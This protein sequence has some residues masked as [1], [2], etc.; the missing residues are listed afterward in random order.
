MFAGLLHKFISTYYDDAR[1]QQFLL[2]TVRRDRCVIQPWGLGV[3]VNLKSNTYSLNH[4]PTL[5]PGHLKEL[6][7]LESFLQ[8]NAEKIGNTEFV[9][10][11]D[12]GSNVDVCFLP[13][14]SSI[15]YGRVIYEPKI[16]QSRRD[17]PNY[18]C[19]MMDYHNKTVEFDAN[20]WLLIE[21]KRRIP[22]RDWVKERIEV[23]NRMACYLQLY[24]IEFSKK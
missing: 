19:K 1:F 12:V 23:R 21:Y 2:Q 10:A 22:G 13:R 8:L 5:Y 14:G 6:E 9:C 15:S 11:R 18:G 20:D 24:L 7:A 4:C 16:A 17:D 3:G